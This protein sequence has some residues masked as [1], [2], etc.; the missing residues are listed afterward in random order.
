MDYPNY[1]FLAR[2]KPE[3]LRAGARVDVGAKRRPTDF[4]LWKFSPKGAKRQMEWQ[5]PWGVGFPG[6]HIECSAM[7]TKYL[8][9][10]TRGYRPEAAAA[11][12][13]VIGGPGSDFI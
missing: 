1:G 12:P 2:L 11:L 9:P 7:A 8:G 4:A 6:W 3:Q 13:S 5:S 10:L